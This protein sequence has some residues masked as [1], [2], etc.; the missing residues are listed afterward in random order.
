M[1][2]PDN[3]EKLA[4]NPENPI[5]HHSAAVRVRFRVRFENG[6]VPM[7]LS[8]YRLSTVSSVSKYG[9]DWLAVRFGLVPSTVSL[10][11]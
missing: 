7:F 9:L 3:S 1:A 8:E 11:S 5:F 6:N 4:Q 2:L 10:S